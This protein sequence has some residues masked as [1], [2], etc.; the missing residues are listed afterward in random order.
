MQTQIEQAF[1]NKPASG[2]TEEHAALFAKF[3]AS[4]NAGEIRAACSS[5]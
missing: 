2:Y 1:D 4:L 3:K 5:V